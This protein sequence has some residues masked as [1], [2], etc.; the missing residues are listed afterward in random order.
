NNLGLK[1]ED[2]V[3]FLGMY[4]DHL[5]W[6]QHQRK[7]AVRV[8]LRLSPRSSCKEG[9]N[10]MRILTVPCLYIYIYAMLFVVRN[11][12]VYQTNNAI[13]HIRTKQFEKL[14]VS[15]VRLSWIQRGVLY[16][17]IIIYNN[18]PQNI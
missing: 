5:N 12:N 10:R 8:M 11:H 16:S 18:L 13:H 1:V 2:N 3:K 17:S 7:R 14:H 15:S 9:F 6:K 4:V